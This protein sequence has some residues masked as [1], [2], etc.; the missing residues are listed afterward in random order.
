[1][2]PPCGTFTR[3]REKKIPQWQLD[4]GAP[5]PRPLRSTDQPEGLPAWRLTRQERTKV[6]KGNQIAWFCADVA[7]YCLQKNV[8]FSIENPSRSILWELPQYQALLADERV[9]KV[10]FHACMF[11][12]KRDKRT[13]FVTN[14]P[15]PL[16]QLDR[17]CTKDHWHAPW[18]LH[19]HK[20]WCFATE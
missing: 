15:A 3:A 13:A 18:G 12:G 17:Q 10:D 6:Y 4:R 8:W 1:M 11:G 20:G 19:W 14:C 9:G 7:R 5:C 2:G 16:T